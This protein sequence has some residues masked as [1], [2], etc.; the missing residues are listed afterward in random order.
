[1][2]ADAFKSL[3]VSVLR[4]GIRHR[5][6][7]HA[8][9]IAFFA[10]LS[11]IPATVT[12]GGVLQ[13]LSRVGGPEL[14]ERGSEGATEAIRFL[15]GPKLADSVI[16]PFVK[17][18]LSQTR[19]PAITGLILTAWL[20][21]RAF[22]ALAHALDVA[23]EATDR[24]PSRIQ[25]LIALGYSVFAV[26]VVAVTLAL[27]VLGWHNGRAG[28]DRFMGQTPVVA[29]LWQVARWP[30]LILIL[31]GVVVGIYR[32]GPNVGHTCRQCLPGAYLAVVLWVA[33]AVAFRA[34][35][36]VGAAAPTGVTTHDERVI[37]IGRAV[38]A[39]I[40]T[41]IWMYVSAL[42]ILTG[43]ELNGE[44]RRRQRSAALTPVD[45]AMVAQ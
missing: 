33:A 31:L 22:H 25:R 19:G 42:A 27:M 24:R 16:N 29:Q 45:T 1:M 23:F 30:L 43:A 41:A 20:T 36:T 11:L 7:G 34:Y 44:L 8:A 15:I 40:A 3:A 9:E 4:A 14:A 21:S 5:T 39:S 12:L 13:I 6:D 18:Q 17:T 35:L 26:A 32:F 28:I 2:R 10:L 37:L 38:G